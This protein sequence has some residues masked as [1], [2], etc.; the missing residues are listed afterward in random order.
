MTDTPSGN[1][2]EPADEGTQPL[3]PQK[4]APATEPVPLPPEY[5][6][7]PAPEPI[8]PTGPTGSTEP[9]APRR[10][11][12]LL[13][14]GAAALVLGIG[15]GGYAVGAA[16]AGPDHPEVGT[17]R[18]APPEGFA[19]GTGAPDHDSDDHD[20][21]GTPDGDHDDESDGEVG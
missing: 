2:W 8:G 12:G 5:G 1:R 9:S 15:T 7:T 14:A 17:T 21:V 16:T 13:V 6:W 18:Q 10:R 3:T 11:T 4:P 19:P 20:G